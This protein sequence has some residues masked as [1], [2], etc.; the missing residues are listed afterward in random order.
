[1][2][3]DFPTLV[4]MAKSAFNQEAL[5]L[6]VELMEF[7]D[8]RRVDLAQRMG[9]SPPYISNV[10]NGRW[11]VSLSFLIKSLCALGYQLRLDA[12]DLQ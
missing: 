5:E 2:D 3:E 6:I 1:M 8:V 10:L 7:D 9:V 4:E 11:P 12:V